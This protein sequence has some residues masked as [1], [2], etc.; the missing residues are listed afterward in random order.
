MIAV[1]AAFSAYASAPASIPARTGASLTAVTAIARVAGALVPPSPSVSTKR[2]VRAAVDGLSDTLRKVT[3]RTSACTA[4]G[5]AF[6][7]SVTTSGVVPLPPVKVPI[8][9]PPKVTFD[10]ETPIWPA[11]VPSLRISSRSSAVPPTE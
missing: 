6:A 1:A 2:A 5:V 7:L 9:V 8:V 3:L 11:P 10:P 4:A